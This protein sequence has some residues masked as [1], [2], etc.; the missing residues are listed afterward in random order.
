MADLT[1]EARYRYALGLNEPSDHSDV[2]IAA[3]MVQAVPYTDGG[4]TNYRPGAPLNENT[5]YYVGNNFFIQ[6]KNT[7][8]QPAHVAILDLHSGGEIK[9]VWPD[10][11]ESLAVR[12]NDTIPPGNDWV[13]LWDGTD[14][15]S[16]LVMNFLSAD[17]GEVVKVMATD[18]YVDYTPLTGGARGANR[19]PASPFDDLLA[20][21]PG[22]QTRGFGR[23]IAPSSWST[24]TMV[25]NVTK[26]VGRG[27]GAN[28]K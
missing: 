18:D 24:A 11:D 25:L 1:K 14:T 22:D 5:D 26:P 10:P 21:L 15:A 28:S 4:Q 3:R 7:G 20:P 6:V 12:Q 23:A 2:H 17:T 19:G 27:I 13:T 9:I 8:N 16:D